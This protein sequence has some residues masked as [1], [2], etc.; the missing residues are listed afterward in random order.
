MDSC[1][2][3]L[4]LFSLPMQILFPDL[5]FC[6]SSFSCFKIFFICLFIFDCIGYQL[7]H[8]GSFV[9]VCR[10]LSSGMQAQLPHSTWDLSSWTR[11]R[12]CIP[13]VG[14]WILN[15]WITREG[16]LI[17]KDFSNSIIFSLNVLMSVD[18]PLVGSLELMRILPLIL[19][20]YSLSLCLVF[21]SQHTGS[22]QWQELYFYFIFA[23]YVFLLVPFIYMKELI[24]ELLYI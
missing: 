9:A 8:V 22:I 1:W 4:F 17:C 3:C 5:K 14:R 13:C 12:T 24:N 7:W 16:P 21:P 23:C 10:L 15:H 19:L 20:F 18:L 2:V 6:V 11:D